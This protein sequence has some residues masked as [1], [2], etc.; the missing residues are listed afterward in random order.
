MSIANASPPAPDHD[1]TYRRLSCLLRVAEV[2]NASLQ[3]DEVLEHILGQATQILSAQS[4]SIMLLDPSRRRL[5]V[6]AARGPRARQIQGRRQLLGE[7]IAGWVA[8]HGSPLLLQG[9]DPDPRIQRICERHDVR[10]AL[11]V[12][13]GTDGLTLGVISVSNHTA[14]T[15]FTTE[16]L[17]LLIAISHQAALAIRNAQS[18]AEIQRQR[19]T[20]ERLL[21]EVTRAQEEERGRISLQIHDGPAQTMFA[22]LRNLQASRSATSAEEQQSAMETLEQS[23]HHA[24]AETRAVMIDLR[25][26]CLDDKGLFAALRQ[27]ADQFQRRTGVRA[28]SR[29]EGD[30]GRLPSMVASAFYRMAQEALTNVW[31]HAGATEVRISLEVTP[32]QCVM[33]IRDDGRGFSPGSTDETEHIGLRSLHDRTQLLGGELWVESGPGVGTIVRISAPLTDGVRRAIRK[34]RT[35]SRV[36]ADCR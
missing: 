4:G 31:K 24:I 33:E 20:V 9:A 28:W 7:G 1:Q 32:R 12:P 18:F 17:D 22:A 29:K 15:P 25:P 6:V 21:K 8:L 10:D 26:L 5:G 11:C 36:A 30:D 19:E 3:L 14:H 13:L 27:F 35:V 16:D 23:I 2:L 34:G